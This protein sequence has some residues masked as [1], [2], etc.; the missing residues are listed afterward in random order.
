VLLTVRHLLTRRVLFFGGKGGVGKTTCSSALALAASREGKR[1]LLVSTDPAHSTSDIL[2][3]SIGPVEREI[4][5][6][7]H[8][9][10]IDPEESVRRYVNEAKTRLAGLFR[11]A[12]V[13]A[14]A[15][16]I[17]AAAEMPGVAET[18]LFDRVAGLLADGGDRFDIVVFDTAPTGHSLRLLRLP[19][20][21]A[22]W[23]EALARRRR[24][25]GEAMA[26]AGESTLP[27]AGERQPDPVLQI[28]EARANRLAA[29]RAMLSRADRVGFVWVLT[30]E[31]LPIEETARGA[32]ALE[33]SGMAI[34]GIVVNRVLP[35]AA[36]GA[37]FRARKAQE[38]AYL[39][40]IARRFSAW[41]RIV[42]PQFES[43][44]HGAEALERV[45]RCLLPDHS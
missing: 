16:Q 21:M 28:L 45:G 36:D 35:E 3:I 14:A 24:E 37:Y 42:V 39:D 7:L 20:S 29:V 17:E 23:I 8:A 43:D 38:R 40:E 30:P 11:P 9:L 1:V 10:E 41:P 19:E 5:P 18:A 27:A 44:V 6:G 12:V 13:Q 2:G 4:L 31:R 33:H 34:A 26:A 15:R 32:H 25:S 22:V